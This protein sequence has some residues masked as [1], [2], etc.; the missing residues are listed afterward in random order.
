MITPS[1]VKIYEMLSSLGPVFCVYGNKLRYNKLLYNLK[2]RGTKMTGYELPNIQ[3]KTPLD[4][5][6][7]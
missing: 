6:S 7:Q 1:P 3:N 5:K 2:V 4:V